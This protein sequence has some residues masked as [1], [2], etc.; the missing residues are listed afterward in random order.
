VPILDELDPELKA[1]LVELP[2]LDLRDIPEARVQ[3]AEMYA[4]MAVAEPLVDVVRSD[5]TATA[6]AESDGVTVRV[7]RPREAKGPLPALVW[8]QG[9][10][11]VLT[12][13]DM[14]D[15]FCEGVALRHG[16]LVV[17]VDWRRAPEH[18]F[19]GAAEDGHAA[20]H[21]TF[22]N[23]AELGV[24]PDRVVVGGHS[25]GGGTA[26]AVAL[27]L[28]DRGEFSA[29]HQLLAYPM[30]D[31]RQT[32]DSSRRVTDHEVW[33]RASNE[34]AW[35]AY[36]GEAYGGDDVSPYAAPARAEDLTGLP[37]TTILVG[38]LDLFLDED[39]EYARRL[40]DAGVRTELHVY[41]AA[42]HAFDRQAPRA[43]V[44]IRFANEREAALSR[45]FGHV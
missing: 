45:A 24:D 5:H 28:R 10:G 12:A 30:L 16:C 43:A 39:V 23:A 21:W 4:Q 11:Y 40:I 19:P 29:C 3:L 41:P 44:S 37:P 13:P 9:G 34:I 27:I 17:S 32:T 8:I 42:H 2:H 26:A 20:A 38:G 1:V 35:R 25:S 6:D 22:T 33:D 14:D 18:Q 7:F 36:L 15:R 31:D